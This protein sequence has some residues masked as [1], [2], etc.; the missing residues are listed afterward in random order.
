SRAG[1][2]RSAEV[3]ASACA[4]EGRRFDSGRP[5]RLQRSEVPMVPWSFARNVPGWRTA[6][7]YGVPAA[8][9]DR[10]DPPPAGG[11]LAR[12]GGGGRADARPLGRGGRPDRPRPARPVLGG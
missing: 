12:G 10:G 9:G 3:V 7:R 5:H 1:W 11:G 4:A 8:H 2:G 6:R